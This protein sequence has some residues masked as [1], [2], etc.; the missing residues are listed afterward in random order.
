MPRTSLTATRQIYTLPCT[1]SAMTVT[2][3]LR[4]SARGQM[5]LP[6]GARHRWGLDDG[7]DVGYLDLGDAILIVPQG[8][9]ELRRQLLDAVTEADWAA[10]RSGFGDPELADA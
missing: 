10:A 7:G 8:A 1:L 9:D 3:G 2:G 4:V 5:S 6:A